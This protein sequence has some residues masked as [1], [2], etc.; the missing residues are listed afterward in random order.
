MKRLVLLSCVFAGTI[1][2]HAKLA[3]AP[4]H[5]GN[6]SDLRGNLDSLKSARAFVALPSHPTSE[7][8]SRT[9]SLA[10]RVAYQRAI[11]E[12]YWRHR[13]WPKDRPDPKP[14]LDEVMP[15]AQLEQ[16]VVGYLRNS[17]ALVG[18]WQQPVSAK[19]LQAEMDRMAQHTQQPEVLHELFAALGNDPFVIAECLARPALSERL[20]TSLY[21]YDQR[22][23]GESKQRAETELR[24]HHTVEQMKRT[25][26]TYSE[27]ELVRSENAQRCDAELGVRINK[28]EW[29]EIVQTLAV[30]FDGDK[31]QSARPQS[32]AGSGHSGITQIKT[33]ELSP[34][35]EDENRYYTTAIISMTRDRLK[36]ATIE[37]RKEPL[38]SWRARVETQAAQAMT[39]VNGNYTLPTILT[40]PNGCAD[41]W[42]PS[43]SLNTPTGR[44]SHAAVWTG[45]EMIIWGGYAGT[46]EGLNTGGR[47]DPATGAW[48]STSTTNAPS[49]RTQPTAVWTGSEMIVWGG[50]NVFGYFNTG[51]RFNPSTDSWTTTTEANAPA[52]RT[53]QTAVWTGSEM[54]VWGGTDGSIFLDTGGRYN[55]VADVW[56]TTSTADAPTGREAHTAIWTGS[57]MIIWGGYDVYPGAVNTGGRYNP[58]TNSWTPTTTSDAP[59]ARSQHKAVWTGSE[60]IIWGGWDQW[61]STY[62][63]TGSRY[64]PNT[65]SWTAINTDSA[66]SGRVYHTAIWSGSELIVWGGRGELGFVNT[67][68]RYNLATNSWTPTSI[69]NATPGRWVHTAIWTGNE[70]IVWGGEGNGDTGFLS[71]GGRYNPATDMWATT[72]D[73]PTGRH[74]HTVVWTGTEMIIWG[75]FDGKSNLST[76]GKYSPST[77]SWTTT[78]TASAPDARRFH[79]AVWTGTEMIMWGGLVDFMGAVNTGGKYNPDTNS[80]TVVSTANAP[81]ARTFHTAVWAGSE[82]IVWGG[83]DS[84]GNPFNTGGRYKPGTNSWVTTNTA[85]APVARLRHTAVWTGNEM[86]IWGGT[87]DGSSNSV[88]TG[89][90]YNSGTDTW[91][92]CSTINAPSARYLHTAVWAGSEMIVW[93]GFDGDTRFDT[94]GRYN[95]GTDS[96]APTTSAKAPSGRDSHTTIW[97]GSEMIVWG[98]ESSG[99]VNTGGRYNPGTDS[100]I[101]TATTHHTPIGRHSHTAIWSGREMIVWAGIGLFGRLNSG[102]IYCAQSAPPAPTPTPRPAALGNISTRL[103]VGTGAN[104]MIAGFIVQGSVPKRVLVRAPGPS[105]TQL[106]VPN[107]LANPRLEL[108]ETSNIIGINDNWQTTQVGGVIISDQ[109][110]EIQNTGLAPHDPSEPALIATLPPGSYTA[111]VDGV[112]SGTGIGLVEVYDLAATSGSL[113]ANI[114]TRGLVQTGDSV[115]IAGFIVVTQPTRVIIRAIGPSLAQFGVPDALANPELELHDASSLI[116]RNDDW[117]ATQIGGIITGDQVA[118]IQSS[119]LPPSDAAESAII[120]TLQPGSYTAVVRGV[121]TTAGNA[122]VEVYVLQ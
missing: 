4:Y 104:V 122:L 58:F 102:G 9:L 79:T 95:P 118:A 100:W 111:I 75:G 56:T 33:G 45:S 63:N 60:M 115:M 106:G 96:W 25:G 6:L 37:W 46:L 16:K 49:E 50:S 17:Q 40:S 47:Y 54:I 24:G 98:G 34:L 89:G 44:E 80:W 22:F 103:Q 2:V 107:A 39:A 94:G 26:G 3:R 119:Q 42:R 120:A 71:T 121:N 72:G 48:T 92:T 21:A 85:N 41:S 82:M 70:M 19:Q 20:L 36:L 35:Q 23:H 7:S 8:Q 108:H 105:L 77:D 52:G 88:N 93:G 64:N 28:L 74:L 12:V 101:A 86:I 84:A 59:D 113:L 61:F 14:S 38:E 68:G 110:S 30:M 51:G 53:R 81:P 27:I 32:E 57:E 10:D 65:N 112:N 78:S 76:G 67:G 18:Y 62:F 31:N 99:V 43:T 90:K 29:D 109:V 117:Q 69:A 1:T 15:P 73:A 116:G 97:T 11:E 66:P 5:F 114:S 13:I 91:T 55:P 87:P 83:Y